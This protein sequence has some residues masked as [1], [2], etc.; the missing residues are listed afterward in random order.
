[1]TAAG[2]TAQNKM[3]LRRCLYI[4]EGRVSSMTFNDAV[5]RRA[6]S[7]FGNRQPVYTYVNRPPGSSQRPLGLCHLPE[8]TT[9]GPIG[10]R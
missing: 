6:T 10:F 3:A 1:V 2:N 4:C 8:G 9:S 5:W 7:P